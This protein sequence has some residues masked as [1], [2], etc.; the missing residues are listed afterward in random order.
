MYIDPSKWRDGVAKEGTPRLEAIMA[1]SLAQWISPGCTFFNQFDSW[2]TERV[3]KV[4]LPTGYVHLTLVENHDTT[5]I[6]SSVS[7][8][9]T[10][11]FFNKSK[12]IVGKSSISLVNIHRKI[13]IW[14][15]PLWTPVPQQLD[16]PKIQEQRETE[17]D[18][19]CCPCRKCIL[20]LLI[21]SRLLTW[22]T[23]NVNTILSVSSYIGSSKCKAWSKLP[24]PANTLM[25]LSTESPTIIKMSFCVWADASSWF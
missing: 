11:I 17:S 24:S 22:S 8:G 21:S 23:E 2:H 5:I 25:L 16:K 14:L 10:A 7:S 19:C 18:A 1:C 15:F 4:S 20:G 3:S 9:F 12:Q 13:R 6:T